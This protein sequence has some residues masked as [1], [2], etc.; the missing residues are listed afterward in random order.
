MA[1]LPREEGC[2]VQWGLGPGLGSVSSPG[3][4]TGLE[5]AHTMAAASGQGAAL[6]APASLRMP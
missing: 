2:S 4:D 6:A 3:R 1:L 5:I